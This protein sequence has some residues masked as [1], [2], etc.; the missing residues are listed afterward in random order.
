[1]S[2]MH[3]RV[4]EELVVGGSTSNG[5][6]GN[7]LENNASSDAGGSRA[8]LFAIALV[9]LL[10][11]LGINNIWTLVF[12]VGLLVSIFLH[13]VGHFVTARKTGMKVTQFF[14]GFGPRLWSRQK[15]EVE[16]GARAIPLGAFVRIIGMNSV[17]EVAPEDEHLAYRNK[18]Y[19]RQLLVITAGSVMHMAIAFV[20]FLGVYVFA[21][22]FTES[23][24]V[25]VLRAPAVGSPAEAAGIQEGDIIKSFNGVNL[26]TRD[27]LIKVITSK[28]P[29]EIVTIIVGRNQQELTVTATLASNPLD[30]QVGYLGVGSAS[31]DY[32]KQGVLEAAGHSVGDIART[33]VNSVRGVVMALNPANSIRALQNP[34]ENLETRPTTVV[35]ASQVGGQLGK[36]D[37]LKAVLLL[38]ASVNVFVGVFNMFPLLP[39]DGGH[40][41]IATYER[42]RS[43]AGRRYRAN[44][45]KMIPLTTLVM[46]L[47]GVLLF[48]GLYL[49]IT[50]PL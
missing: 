39:F 30:A 13:E 5:L 9:A 47:L 2:S 38:L 15:G 33:V 35:G 1:M 20:L 40:A 42:I 21:G 31:T 46:G 24:K 14:M 37:G 16:Y 36:E 6:E 3:E 49:D 11:W 27:D 34:N 25:E 23:G 29:G 22:R 18:S 26:S 43:R 44:V 19:P 32:V 28:S 50:N 45:N 41:A 17:D 10:V 12:V 7:G 4:R 48:V 8:A